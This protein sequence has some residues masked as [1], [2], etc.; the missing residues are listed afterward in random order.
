MIFQSLARYKDENSM[1]IYKDEGMAEFI[2][3]YC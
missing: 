1:K 3:I 2:M